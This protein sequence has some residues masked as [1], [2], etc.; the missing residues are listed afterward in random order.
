MNDKIEQIDLPND[1]KE[2]MGDT[3]WE[4]NSIGCSKAKVFKWTIEEDVHYLKVD[5]IDSIFSLEK[6][7][8][9]LDWLVRKLE[10]PKVIYFGQKENKEFLLLSEIQG[11]VSFKAKTNNE[12]RRNIKILADGL[13]KIHSIPVSDCP[14]NKSPDKLLQLAKKRLEEGNIN[15]SQFDP[16][17]ADQTPEQLFKNILELKPKKFDLVFTHGDYCLPNI[18]VKEGKLSGFIDWSFGGINDRYFDFAAVFWSIGYNYGE[19]WIKYFIED[20]GIENINWDKI[21][22]FQMLN[23]FFQHDLNDQ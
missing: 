3:S 5:D 15:P 7:K 23:E 13:K 9:I 10:V 8:I 12:K 6:E 4:E 18:L 19:E 14:I 16:R 21:K 17:W 1:L 2:I 20:Y 11:E 22:F